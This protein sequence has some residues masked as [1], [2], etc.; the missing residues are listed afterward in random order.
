MSLLDLAHSM[1]AVQRATEERPIDYF[2]WLPCQVEFFKATERVACMRAGNQALG[3]STALVV[4]MLWLMSGEHPYRPC[5]EPPVRCLFVTPS[6]EGMTQVM[7]KIWQLADHAWFAEGTEFCERQQRF[8]GKFPR[9]HFKNGSVVVFRSGMGAALNLAG[10]TVDACFVDEPPVSS[11]VYSESLKRLLKA[12]S[13]GCMRLAFTPVNADVRWLKELCEAGAIADYHTP[14]TPEALIPVG[15]DQPLKLADGTP[16]DEAWINSIE[17]ESLG[18]E[19]PVIVHGE[20]EFRATEGIFERWAPGEMVSPKMPAGDV[21]VYIGIDHGSGRAGSSVAV[22]VAVEK[23]DDLADSQIYVLSEYV[24]NAECTEDHDA[25][26]ILEA[27]ERVPGLCWSD[28]SEAWGDRPHHG[29]K[30][31]V[32]KKSNALL[33]SALGK[34]ERAGV[35]S[36]RPGYVHPNLRNVKRGRAGANTSGA[37]SY[38][39]TW[40]HRCMLKG[41]FSVHPRCT[42]LI[43]CLSQYEGKS[44][45]PSSHS[46]D[47][48]RYA[49]RSVIYAPVS[50]SKAR[51]SVTFR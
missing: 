10:L 18:H 6:H 16:C 24:S 34:A 5:K 7:Q 4:D 40:L 11:R 37:V 26:G 17:A 33:V 27:I 23:A 9:L 31:S 29:S 15:T 14:L 43:A 36:I 39:C 46:I 22:I 21:P 13:E 28:L 42:N 19:I 25:A 49:L 30:G 41:N 48:L 2:D 47:A 35:H 3:K 44:N 20:W 1:M 45:S 32:S 38:G 12:G 51:P 8:T 50:R